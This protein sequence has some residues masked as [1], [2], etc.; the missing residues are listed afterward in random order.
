VIILYTID[1]SKEKNR[2]YV[3]IVGDITDEEMKSYEKEMLSIVDVTT[4]GFTMFADLLESD[5]AFLCKSGS[6]QSIRNYGATK[7]FKAASYA[8]NSETYELHKKN[9]FQGIKN[10]FLS[11]AEAERFLDNA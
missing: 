2:I 8:L 1:Y 6:F 11:I 3:K 10:I 9:P 7:G 4:P 5:E